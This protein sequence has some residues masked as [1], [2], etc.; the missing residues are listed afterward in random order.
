MTTLVL[1]SDSITLSQALK[2]AGLASSGGQAKALVRDGTVTVNGSV[3][4]HPGRKLSAG[5]RFGI[6]GETEWLLARPG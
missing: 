4:T 1:R 6:A 3:E 5:D 2:A